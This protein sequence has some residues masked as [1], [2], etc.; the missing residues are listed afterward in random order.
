[1]ENFRIETDKNRIELLDQ[2]FYEKDGQYYP[3]VTTILEAYPKGQAFFEWLKVAGE[4]ADDIR[5][6]FGKRGSVVHNLTEQYD[7]GLEVTLMDDNGRAKYTSVEWAMFERY[8]EFMDR[9][10]PEVL[11]IEAHYCNPELGFGGTLDRVVRIKD[12][13]VLLDI[14][15]SNYLHNHFWLQMAAYEKLYQYNNSLNKDAVKIDEIAI[16]WL[17]AKTRT[18][19]RDN[20]I[21]GKG[22]Q[23]KFPEKSIHDYWKLFSATQALWNAEFGTMKP[24]NIFYNLTHKKNG[25]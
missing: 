23:L 21:Q 11:L 2:R 25:N 12:K 4:K 7:M 20:T 15:T 17:N 6:E 18:E 13:I 1:M 16:L 8:V 24:R 5:D 10:E 9:F 19:G 14:K 3:S 22:W